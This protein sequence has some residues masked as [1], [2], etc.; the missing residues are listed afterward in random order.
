MQRGTPRHRS[1]LAASAKA[2]RAVSNQPSPAK[3]ARLGVR[4]T[5]LGTSHSATSKALP[6]RRLFSTSIV[7]SG[8]LAV[9]EQCVGLG[10][11]DMA[12]NRAMVER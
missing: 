9:P 11:Q 3:R 5:A 6:A 10:L 4:S 1:Y 12:E 8:A 7:R 2:V